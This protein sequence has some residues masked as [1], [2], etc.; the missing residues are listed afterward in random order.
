MNKRLIAGAVFAAIIAAT[1]AHAAPT[2][3]AEITR[4]IAGTVTVPRGGPCQQGTSCANGWRH[5]TVHAYAYA[6]HKDYTRFTDPSGHYSF[7]P[8]HAGRYRISVTTSQMTTCPAYNI[9]LRSDADSIRDIA[10]NNGA[11]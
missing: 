4:R 9:R 11:Q 2:A 1:P 10:C 8:Y 5:A 6:Y 7:G 3:T